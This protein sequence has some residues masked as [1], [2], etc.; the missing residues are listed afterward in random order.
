MIANAESGYDFDELYAEVFLLLT[1]IAGIGMGIYHT[2]G[3]LRIPLDDFQR[4]NVSNEKSVESI[5]KM[6]EISG[7]IADG[8][9]TFLTQ[10]YIFLGIFIILFSIL[11]FF[12]AE[13]DLGELWVT[14]AFILGGATSILSGFIGMK[15]A[16][17]T[18]VKVT[19]E[20]SKSIQDAFVVAFK[21]GAVLG[22][23]LVGIGLFM[24]TVLIMI[25]RVAYLDEYASKQDYIDMFEAIAGYGLGG[26]SIALFGRVGGG[27]YTKAADVGAD[28]VGKVV[29]GLDEDSP[30][31]PGVIADNVGDNVGDIA[32]MGS[33][34]FGSFAEA[35]CAALVVGAT[36]SEIVF[37]NGAYYYYPLM[38]TGAGILI[39]IVTSIVALT[40]QKPPSA[41]KVENTLK[42]QLIISTVLMTPTLYAVAY[43]CLPSS[44]TFVE[45]GTN[46][47]Y[48]HAFICTATGLWSG[49][50]IGIVTEYYT[51]NAYSPVQEV[52]ESCKTGA[53]PNIIFG[54]ALGFYSVLVPIICLAVTIFIS[55]KF[56]DMYGIALGAL[57]MLSTLTIGLTIDGY[58]PIADN[59]G[60]IAEMCELDECRQITDALDAAGNTTA[61]IG[62]GFA[63][64]SACLVALALFGAFVT[65]TNLGIVNILQPLQF[66]GLIIGAML[67]YLFT[68]M[69][70]KSVGLAA[71]KMIVEIQRQ[72]DTYR[73]L[74]G[75]ADPDYE[76]CI[77]IS[78]KSSLQYMIAP[79]LLVLLSPFF[80][81]LFFGA[82]GVSGLLAGAIVSGIQLAISFSNAGG[83]WDNAKKYVEDDKLVI[84]GEVRG[85]NTEEHKAAVIGDTVGDPLKD[86][87]G[88][89]LNILIKLM[90]I[91]S[92]VFGGFFTRV[93]G[94]LNK[95]I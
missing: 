13:E 50:I 80:I 90:A 23:S 37:S 10:E 3:I 65:R 67:P 83:A 45:T 95:Y 51:S 52:A 49:L 89:S 15:I 34:L 64:G 76:S 94:I 8:A 33:D 55:F 70:M 69:T 68:A 56:C 78:T 84:N 61:A 73:I 6:R 27:I 87:S 79:G 40:I 48:Y 41:D 39:G 75:E 43:F 82:E 62:K 31:N 17:T 77:A 71:K 1:S 21:G 59:A 4:F 91:T 74:E 60:G 11:L 58:G 54:L 30:Q 47:R 2:M 72:F 20:A 36:S 81:G 25:Y 38:I 53:A 85:K 14:S 57:G 12:T 32:G 92:L 29:A 28:L 66:S 16:V 9:T 88:P 22:F 24:L 35:T 42:W 86:T 5:R 46:C 7:L 93:G 63:I 44:F 19:K 26:S 18:N